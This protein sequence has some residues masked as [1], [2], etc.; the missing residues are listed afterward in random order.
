MICYSK[1]IKILNFFVK[2]KKLN[3]NKKDSLDLKSR[4]Q[5]KNFESLTINLI[6]VAALLLLAE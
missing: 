5:K 1:L 6:T 4:D 3:K 2:F